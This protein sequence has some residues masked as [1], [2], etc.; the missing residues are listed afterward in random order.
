MYVCKVKCLRLC[1]AEYRTLML[2]NFYNY[3]LWI[4]YDNEGVFLF[5]ALL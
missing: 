5:M 1:V 2:N 4:I 3:F